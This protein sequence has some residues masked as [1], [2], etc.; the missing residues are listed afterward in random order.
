MNEQPDSPAPRTY[1]A[2]ASAERARRPGAAVWL[3]ALAVVLAPLAV[4]AAPADEALELCHR[5]AFTDDRRA[6]ALVEAGLRRATVAAAVTAD[7]PAAHFAVFCNLA[8][9]MRLLGLGLRTLLDLRRAHRALDRSLALDPDYADA[10]AGKGALLYFTP[11][12]A[13]GDAAQGERLIRGVL[14]RDPG[15]PTRLVLVAALAQRGAI[16]AAEREA[17]RA[18]IADRQRTPHARAAQR[19]LLDHLCGQS[20]P[21]GIA[22]ALASAC[23]GPSRDHGHSPACRAERNAP[24]PR[25]CG[26][27]DRP[28]ADADD[29]TITRSFTHAHPHHPPPFA[30]PGDRARPGRCHRRDGGRRGQH[31]QRSDRRRRPPGATRLRPGGVRHQRRADRR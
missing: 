24:H 12:L 30:G 22:A 4:L 7:D 21:A 15:N 16:A 9:R 3:A 26:G 31:Q 18:V 17:R 1:R 11:S 5:A 29:L 13:G 19:A 27:R 10:L 25:R 6:L 2:A 20:W 28:A 8:K 23:R 14:A